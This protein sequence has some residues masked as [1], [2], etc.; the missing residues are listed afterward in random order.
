MPGFIVHVGAQVQCMHGA[1]AQ[2]TAIEPRVLL[3]AQAAVVTLPSPQYH[4]TGCPNP[5]PNGSNGPCL[6]AQF[7][8]AATKVLAGGKPLLIRN[9]SPGTC[10]PTGATANIVQTQMKVTAT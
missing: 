5:P 9:G 1:P 6:T 2:P 10:L 8:S 7:T 3:N 4:V